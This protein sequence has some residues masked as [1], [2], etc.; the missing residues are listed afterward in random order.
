VHWRPCSP[1][2]AAWA[3]WCHRL[4]FGAVVLLVLV[5]LAFPWF[6]PLFY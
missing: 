6:A 4:L 2:P 3:R 1:R 5:A